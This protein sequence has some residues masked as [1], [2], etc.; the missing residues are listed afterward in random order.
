ML[1]AEVVH[2]EGARYAAP[3]ILVPA[4][5]AGPAAWRGCAGFLA[6]RGWECHLVD[7]RGAGQGGLVARGAAIAEYAAALATP[8]VLVGHDAGGLAALL[9]AVRHPMAAVVLVAPIVPGSG[10]ARSLVRSPRA[11]LALLRGRPVA[12]PAGRAAV[13]FL[14][15]RGVVPPQLVD[16]LAP[17]PAEVVRDVAWGRAPIAGVPGLPVLVATG[18]SDPLASP[19]VLAAFARAIGAEC[20]RLPG[21]AHWPLFG[22]AWQP[23]IDVVH[24]W[25]VRR[26]G[27]PLLELYEEAMAE[28]EDDGETG[29]T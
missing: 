27:A 15:D 24:R 9:A 23:T 12:P 18:D 22:R 4:L 17:E 29:S 5:W 1:S 13:L 25:I 2:A 28:R 3:L 10:A 7:V 21:A 19:D 26:L 6:H 8:P 14:G 20:E 16:V 11:L